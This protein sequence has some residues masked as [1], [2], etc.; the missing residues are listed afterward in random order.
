MKCN[1]TKD[2]PSATTNQLCQSVHFKITYLSPLFL[3]LIHLCI[4]LFLSCMAAR[5]SCFFCIPITVLAP[6]TTSIIPTS[7]PVARQPYGHILKTKFGSRLSLDDSACKIKKQIT[8]KVYYP[9][10]NHLW[11]WSYLRSMPSLCQIASI[12]R[13]TCSVNISCRRSANTHSMVFTLQK[14]E[15]QH[16]VKS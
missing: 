13:I 4:S 1:N 3:S 8:S 7:L 16:I 11:N 2:V 10:E 12:I 15:H 6:R 5:T 9:N 14:F